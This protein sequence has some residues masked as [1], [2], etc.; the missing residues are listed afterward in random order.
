VEERFKAASAA[1]G[2]LLTD[3]NLI[4]GVTALRL[5]ARAPAWPKPRPPPPIDGDGWEPA[6]PGLSVLCSSLLTFLP[7]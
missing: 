1:L 2:C 7:P 5:G 6:L 4:A 3:Y